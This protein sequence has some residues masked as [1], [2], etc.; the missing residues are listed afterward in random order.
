MINNAM[1]V[2]RE[3]RARVGRGRRVFRFRM[4]VKKKALLIW[5]IE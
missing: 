3:I 4:E 1:D 2:G 5:E